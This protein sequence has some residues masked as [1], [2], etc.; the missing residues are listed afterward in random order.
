MRVE[1]E[2]DALEEPE[3]GER[4]TGLRGA[5]ERLG[6]RRGVWRKLLG[7]RVTAEARRAGN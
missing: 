7:G 4:A 3:G 5:G 2:R 6:Y 1:R